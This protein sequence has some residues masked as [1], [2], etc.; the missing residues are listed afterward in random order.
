[1][2]VLDQF[3]YPNPNTVSLEQLQTLQLIAQQVVFSLDGLTQ[4]SSEEKKNIALMNVNDLYQA[5]GLEIPHEFIDISI[6]AGVCLAR[7]LRM[8]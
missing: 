2:L 1:M 8:N 5:F 7:T 3:S 6:E 4:L